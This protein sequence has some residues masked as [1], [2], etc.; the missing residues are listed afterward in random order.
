MQSLEVRSQQPLRLVTVDQYEDFLA[1]RT[2]CE[3]IV[4]LVVR[5]NGIPAS[6]PVNVELSGT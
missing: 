2:V 1:F 5:Q 3:M 6:P 4:D